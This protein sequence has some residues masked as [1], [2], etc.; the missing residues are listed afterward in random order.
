MDVFAD[1]LKGIDNPDHR[2]RME[3]IFAWIVG[4]FP[5]LKPKI[6]WNQP[7]FTDHD[8]FII[9]FSASKQHMAVAP[10][11]AGIVRFSEDIVQAGYDHT[12]ELVRIR[13][14]GPVDYS[15]LEKMIEYNI[16][17]KADCSTFWRK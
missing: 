10:E 17:D 1:Y 4:K 7:M 5:N 6:A 13:W 15:L 11:K 9:G 3:E 16:E 12:K 8:T 2:A 14:D